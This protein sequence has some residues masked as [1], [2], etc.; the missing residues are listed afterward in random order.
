MRLFEAILSANQRASAGD[1]GATFQTADFADALPVAALTCIDPRLNSLL[2]GLLGLG[3]HDFLWLRNPGNVLTDWQ[4]ATMRSLA[5]ACAVKQAKEVAIIG[6]TDCAVRKLSMSQLIDAFRALGVDRPRL[7]DDLVQYFSLF[8]SERQNVVN[9]VCC[10]RQSSLL[11][12]RVPVHGLLVDLDSRKLEW[13]VNGYQAIGPVVGH[14]APTLGKTSEVASGPTLPSS[15]KPA[16]MPLPG[17]APPAAPQPPTRSAETPV[18]PIITP[19]PSAG[20]VI[21]FKRSRKPPA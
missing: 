17:T 10:A 8:A 18:P 9:A 16:T 20:P 3:E 15:G 19:Q 11:G 21:R 13:V 2:P 6:H 1:P 4:G 14:P 5:L 12:P 7:P